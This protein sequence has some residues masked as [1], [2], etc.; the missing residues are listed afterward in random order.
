MSRF[1]FLASG[2]VSAGILTISSPAQ[3]QSFEERVRSW[4]LQEEVPHCSLQLLAGHRS[5]KGELQRG[6]FWALVQLQ[7]PWAG[8]SSRE[9][10]RESWEELAAGEEPREVSEALQPLGGGELRARRLLRSVD[11]RAQRREVAKRELRE[12]RFALAAPEG[13]RDSSA[14][15]QS[16]E[17]RVQREAEQLLRSRETAPE[18]VL[19]PL[20]VR[21]VIEQVWRASGLF[22][23][24]EHLTDLARR[25][26]RSGWAPELRLRGAWGRDH[27]TSWVESGLYPAADATR[28]GKMDLAGEV[29]LTFRLH[30]LFFD[31]A[32]PSLARLRLQIETARQKL[33]ERALE[34][35]LKWWESKR[36][37][38]DLGLLPE[39]RAEHSQR[40]RE[41][42]LRLDVMT[43]GW[44]SQQEKA[45]TK[46]SVAD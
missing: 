43:G 41:L 27:S 21:E 10:A 45:Q 1:L 44:F 23:E 24:S 32:E 20:W 9:R 11:E 17:E 16:Q 36:S 3:A 2:V 37:A 35:L 31:T 26:R 39:E 46:L 19:S 12:A 6:H 25:A 38:G 5:Q 22:Q 40:V 29:R 8:C 28:R 34:L 33:A 13:G 42:A 18:E 30:R 14:E 7:V 15:V 4:E